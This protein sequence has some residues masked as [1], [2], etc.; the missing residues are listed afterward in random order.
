MIE[1]IGKTLLL[2]VFLSIA[3]IGVERGFKVLAPYV[4]KVSPSAA[5]FLAA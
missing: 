4:A 1:K 3:V 2:L 5:V